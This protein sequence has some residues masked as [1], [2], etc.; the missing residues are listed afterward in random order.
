MRD[1]RSKETKLA[2]NKYDKWRKDKNKKHVVSDLVS[3]VKYQTGVVTN[4]EIL[5]RL[6]IFMTCLSIY[7]YYFNW[8]EDLEE[9]GQGGHPLWIVISLTLLVILKVNRD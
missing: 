3:K 8:D 5:Y 4:F 9:A 7:N 1:Y 2:P 6:S